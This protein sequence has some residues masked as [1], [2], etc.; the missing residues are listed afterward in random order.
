MAQAALTSPPALSLRKAIYYGLWL[1][2]LLLWV[3]PLVSDKPSPAIIAYGLLSVL[4]GFAA[5]LIPRFPTAVLLGPGLLLLWM[6]LSGTANVLGGISVAQFARA[7]IGFL[8]YFVFLAVA[9]YLRPSHI[10]R[11]ITAIWILC[12]AVS[13]RTIV[14]FVAGT[15]SATHLLSPGIYRATFFDP[16]STLPFTVLGMICSMHLFRSGG[17]RL[18]FLIFFTYMGLLSQSK[19]IVLTLILA[20]A[21]NYDTFSGFGGRG[22]LWPKIKIILIGLLVV[23]AVVF[24]ADKIPG[25]NRFFLVGTTE[26]VTTL[27]RLGE[28]VNAWQAFKESPVIGKGLGH[29]FL[30]VST[31]QDTFGMIEERNYTHNSIMFILATTGLPGLVFFLIAMFAPHRA[32][33]RYGS[34]SAMI[35]THQRRLLSVYLAMSM[36]IILLGV[37]TASYK[38]IHMN[39]LLGLIH[40]AIWSLLSLNTR[41]EGST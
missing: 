12:V 37:V 30:H 20:M 33:I 29:V 38:L 2:I 25:L 35:S 13:L 3:L 17:L 39:V 6:L 22:G 40:G 31:L 10:S 8:F 32:A 4:L 34:S 14:L 28:I 41:K 19:S 27:G 26:D 23:I 9:V 21:W 5:L 1:A 15:G 36:V 18:L 24:F 11:L 16:F 7:L